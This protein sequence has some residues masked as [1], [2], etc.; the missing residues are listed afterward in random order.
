MKIKILAVIVLQTLIT[1]GCGEKKAQEDKI[2]KIPLT[3]LFVDQ[4]STAE[5]PDGSSWEK[6]FPDIN[7]AINAASS[8]GQKIYVAAG[9]YAGDINK[10][11]LSTKS[12][13][14]LVGGYKAFE[15]YE[16][17]LSNLPADEMTI[18]DAKGSQNLVL[19]EKEAKDISFYGFVFKGVR[20]GHAMMIKGEQDK[21]IDGISISYCK[22]LD[23]QDSRTKG[24]HD[25]HGGGLYITVAKNIQLSHVDF[26]DNLASGRGGAL[27]IVSSQV[28]L[29]HLKFENNQA[30]SG[31]ALAILHGGGSPEVTI[32]KVEFINNKATDL[33]AGGAIL[34][35]FS[36]E[37]LGPVKKN[38]PQLVFIAPVAHSGNK[39]SD[40]ST[41]GSLLKIIFM[42]TDASIVAKNLQAFIDVGKS[43]IEIK[44]SPLASIFITP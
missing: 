32:E 23:N 28:N 30:S 24:S 42:T 27:A 8:N 38:G 22:F 9:T 3:G 4:K 13:I 25:G 17:D 16:K 41:T 44:P 34:A 35:I 2:A 15:Q 21:P 39:A 1:M 18:L 31:G 20:N 43:G 40:I 26:K 5:N 12:G 33:N 19:I 11:D 7:Q 29:K 6:A 37:N 10:L 14:H 36:G